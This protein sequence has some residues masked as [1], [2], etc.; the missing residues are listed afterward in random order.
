M[1]LNKLTAVKIKE[2]RKKLGLTA[3]AIA[4]DM[5]IST[6]AYSRLENGHIEIS[7]SR[8]EMLAEVMKVSIEALLPLTNG[9]N[10]VSHGNGDNIN[11]S[12]YSSFTKNILPGK[13]DANNY[14]IE[15]LTNIIKDLKKNG[16]E[17]ES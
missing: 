7:L 5:G 6:G 4:Q 9:Q 12:P 8:I 13:D 11:A 16:P 17:G 10:Q 1:D 3:D 14:I 15:T 2:T